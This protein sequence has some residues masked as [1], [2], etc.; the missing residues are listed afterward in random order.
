MKY[1]LDYLKH[2]L[3]HMY[4]YVYIIYALVKFLDEPPVIICLSCHPK[5]IVCS[6]SQA[7]EQLCFDHFFPRKYKG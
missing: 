2:T 6:M 3:H 4:N 7:N 5:V 1:N